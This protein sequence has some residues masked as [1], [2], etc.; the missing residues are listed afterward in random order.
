MMRWGSDSS[1]IVSLRRNETMGE[2][3]DPIR[4]FLTPFPCCLLSTVLV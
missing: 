4:I 1:P 3:S 2:E